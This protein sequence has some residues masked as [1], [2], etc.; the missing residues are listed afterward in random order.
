VFKQLAMMIISPDYHDSYAIDRRGESGVLLDCPDCPANFGCH[1][2]LVQGEAQVNMSSKHYLR[3]IIPIRYH[4]YGSARPNARFGEP[5]PN[6]T[7]RIDYHNLNQSMS[8]V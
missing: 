8:N 6:I 1:L 7:S 4:M 3:V 2:F 5:S